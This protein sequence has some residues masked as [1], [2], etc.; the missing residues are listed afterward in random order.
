M[1]SHD[2]R[3]ATLEANSANDRAILKEIHK[4]VKDMKATL[5]KQRGF[6]NGAVAV[7]SFMWGLLLFGVK[8]VW[9][10]VAS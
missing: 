7:L 3:I 9:D 8:L 1:R 4:D 6:V 10:K 2:E 5:N